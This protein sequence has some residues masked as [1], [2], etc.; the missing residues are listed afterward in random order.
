MDMSVDLNSLIPLI[1]LECLIVF[2]SAT[3]IG[4]LI[5]VIDDKIS[6]LALYHQPRTKNNKNGEP[7]YKKVIMVFWY[8]LLLTPFVFLSIYISL[9]FIQISPVSSLDQIKAI[10][11]T[12]AIFTPSA[13]LIF[14]FLMRWLMNPTY[15]SISVILRYRKIDQKDKIILTEIIKERIH[16]FF[17]SYICI[18]LIIF[19]FFITVAILES[20]AQQDISFFENTITLLFSTNL[21]QDTIVKVLIVYLVSLVVLTIINEGVLFKDSPIV[22]TPW[23]KGTQR[24][25]IYY[26]NPQPSIYNIPSKTISFLKIQFGFIIKRNKHL[27]KK[28]YFSYYY[29]EE[30]TEDE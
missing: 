18:T 12:I 11:N 15:S 19:I 29:M 22:Q 27:N 5:S 20:I 24:T 8:Y 6:Q 28:R 17:S 1:L 4:V 16:S 30:T 26:F 3:Y 14:L 25:L 23:R 21:D 10:N 13:A 7:F 9:K 2:I